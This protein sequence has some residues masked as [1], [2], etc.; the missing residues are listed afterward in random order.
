MLIFFHGF[1]LLA[2]GTSYHFFSLKNRGDL[3]FLLITKFGCFIIGVIVI[4]FRSYIFVI[5]V[6]FSL[7]VQIILI[8]YYKRAQKKALKPRMPVQMWSLRGSLRG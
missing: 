2:C 1:P 6:F 4:G 7:I 3:R 5:L 8:T